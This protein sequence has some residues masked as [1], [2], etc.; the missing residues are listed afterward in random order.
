MAIILR[1]GKIAADPWRRL[2]PGADG[3]LPSAPEHGDI[4][5]P[6]A[7]W[8]E[9][10]EAL[11]ARPGRVGVSLRGEDEPVAVADDL[12]HFGVVAVHFP[13]FTDGRG[14]SLAR[15]LR[16][17]YGYRGELRATGDIFRDHLFFLARCGFD[18]FALR[19]G[20]DPQEALAGFGVF[21][22]AY[23]SSV[24]RPLPLFRRRHAA[25]ADRTGHD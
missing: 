22:D 23:Q 24:E 13:K 4:I 8:R 18:A 1:N 9:R 11:L 2:E 19:E 10:R 16:E 20:E 7:A 15:L 25:A 17:R 6:L 12:R 5:V 14:Y 3:V 21:S